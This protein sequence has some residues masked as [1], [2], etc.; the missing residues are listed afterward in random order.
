MQLLDRRRARLVAG[1]LLVAAG[2]AGDV[3][4]AQL[5]PP[6]IQTPRQQYELPPLE[7]SVEPEPPTLLPPPPTPPDTGRLSGALRVRVSAFHFTGNTVFS[8]AQLAAVVE[9]WTGREI[10]SEALE[11]ARQ[12]L[13]LRYVEDGYVTSGAVIPDQKLDDG[14]VELRIVE[15]HLSRVIVD[16]TRWW[17]PAYFEQRLMLGSDRPL[18]VQ[19]LEE[20]LQLLQQDV[21]I[22]RVNARLA[23][24]DR[25]GEAV[26]RVRV[27]EAVP[28][29]FGLG[30]ANDK[31]PSVGGLAGRLGLGFRN[32]TGWGDQLTGAV[33]LTGGLSDGEA[34][35]ELPF[36][37]W[38]TSFQARFRRTE[39][40]ILEKPFDVADINSETQTFGLGFVQPL[41]R[42][43]S[44]EVSVALLGEYRHNQ[45]RI[46]DDGFG[47][48]YTGAGPTNGISKIS[49]L[50]IGAEWI[51][52]TRR[53]V[54]ALR[55][56]ASVGLP[57]LGATQ[58]PGDIPDSQ[59]VSWL[60][61]FQWAER[62][63][64]LYDI[65]L[66]GRADLQ[67]A[68]APLMPLEQIAVGGLRTVRG[69]RENQL[70]RDQ[71]VVASLELRLPLYRSPGTRHVLQLVP[72][73]DIGHGWSH[74]RGD[75]FNPV[76]LKPQTETLTSVGVGLRYRFLPHLLAELYWGSRLNDVPEPEET[77]LQDDGVHFLLS[78]D[79][80]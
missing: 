6:V 25:R 76:Q 70:V 62:L 51:E 69:Y 52:R 5:E 57:V 22:R 74:R 65:E 47:F 44:D 49:V 34:R 53:R 79:L 78:L 4:R 73:V 40:T 28:L 23:P 31:P 38:D 27:E 66:I 63:P 56:L 33:A 30:V 48:E 46:G 19:D 21:R 13:T 39:S 1:C 15:G 35:Y 77:S 16:P 24:G 29:L 50:R 10:D 75:F 17:Q 55:S 68:S 60:T 61:Q 11:A 72:F 80:L 71:A 45:T 7:P 18:R 3:A 12:A 54:I 42:T 64:E 2:L 41:F 67:L 9:P 20:R 43:P 59:F 36:T 37:K 8:D 14:I 32:L 26:L 58:N